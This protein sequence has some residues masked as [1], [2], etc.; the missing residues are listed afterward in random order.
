MRRRDLFGVLI[1]ATAWP[2]AGRAQ[3]PG[4]PQLIGALSGLSEHDPEGQARIAAFRNGL[5]DLGW[6]EGGN[7]RIE[8]R[9]GNGDMARLRAHAAEL[10][11]LRPDVILAAAASAL[12]PLRR[13]TRD[14]PLVFAQVTDPVALGLVASLAHPGGNI[15]GFA[16]SDQGLAAKWLELLKQLAPGVG[17]AAV[18]YQPGAPQTTTLLH[19]IQASARSFHV[20]LATVAVRDEAEIKTAIARFAGRA[21]GSLVIPPSPLIATHRDTIVRLASHH[22]LPAV[23]PYRYFVTRGGLISYGPDNHDLYR[24]A[25]SYVD[26]ILKGEKPGD[27]PIQFPIKYE[28]VLNLKTAKALGLEVPDRL[29]AVANEVIE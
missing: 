14:V 7:V 4:R 20:E 21:N 8:Y 12:G 1:G 13:E 22:R 27:L 16:T 11:S 3:R 28:L 26:R 5:R 19:E 6:T 2:V 25:A 10:V 24:R 9:W 23:Y 15:T 17:F 18:I 29:L